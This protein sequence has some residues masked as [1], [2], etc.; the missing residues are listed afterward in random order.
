[1]CTLYNQGK[2]LRTNQLPADLIEEFETFTAKQPKTASLRPT[3]T[4]AVIARGKEGNLRAIGMRWGW[5]RPEIKIVVNSRDDKL[6]GRLW[7]KADRERRCLVPAESF[8]EWSGEKGSKVQHWFA[9][10]DG[11]PLWIAGLWENSKENGLCYT[12][13]TRCP[14]SP[15]AEVHDRMPCVLTTEEAFAY[16][17]AKFPANAG[18]E[19][20]RAVTNWRTEFKGLRKGEIRPGMRGWSSMRNGGGRISDMPHRT[21]FVVVSRD[22]TVVVVRTEDGME[23][24][25]SDTQCDTGSEYQFSD[26]RWLPECSPRVLDYLEWMYRDAV[27]EVGRLPAGVRRDSKLESIDKL[28]WKLDCYGR[29][30]GYIPTRIYE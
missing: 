16:L 23:W 29:D 5:S 28:A 2:L 21:P 17:D 11:L 20:L 19:R 4:G 27:A 7:A 25:L 22:G 10:A 12:M 24:K 13:V 1:M 30:V 9:A 3:E 15:V 8:C 14:V 26:G 6:A 18:T